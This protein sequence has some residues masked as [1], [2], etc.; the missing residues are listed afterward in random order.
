MKAKMKKIAV[1][2]LGV[3]AVAALAALAAPRAFAAGDWNDAGVKWVSYK[4]GLAAAKKA[5]KPICLIFY[6]DWCPHCKNYSSV[7][8][9]E[10]VVAASKDFVMI[11]LNADQEK[12][13][14][15]QF[16]LDGGYIPRTYFLSSDGKVD[17]SIKARPDKFMYFYD[18]KDPQSVLTGMAEAK[19]KLK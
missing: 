12:E 15:Q 3:F 7:F 4:D 11:R 10:K 8:H 5:N 9:D 13:V 16:A 1:A 14:A 19:K 17:G 2:V 18:E 6:T